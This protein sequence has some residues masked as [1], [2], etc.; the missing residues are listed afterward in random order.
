MHSKNK[1]PIQSSGSYPMFDM[2]LNLSILAIYRAKVS[3]RICLWYLLGFNFHKS[4][5]SLHV[6]IEV[7]IHIFHLYVTY[8]KEGMVIVVSHK[9]PIINASIYEEPKKEWL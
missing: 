7:A 9:R 1:P 5:I 4:C 6:P 2:F 3:D 8:F